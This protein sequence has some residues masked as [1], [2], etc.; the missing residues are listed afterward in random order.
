MSAPRISYL[1]CATARSGSSLLCEALG[2]TGLA[3]QPWEY[4]FDA[5]EPMWRGRWGLPAEAGFDDY[6]GRVLGEGATPNGVW[7]AKVMMGYFRELAG[8]LRAS[9]RCSR[10]RA[11]GDATSGEVLAEVFPALRYVWITRRDK[12]RQAVSLVRAIQTQSWVAQMAPVRSPEYDFAATDHHLQVV[13][14]HEAGWQEF[15]AAHGIVPFV[16]V[17]EDFEVRYQETALALLDFLGVARPRDLRLPPP[18]IMVR[19]ADALSQ[20][21][22]ARFL[23]EKRERQGVERGFP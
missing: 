9:S 1:I 20:E 2:S 18:R 15:F 21:W 5:H 6:L 4:F 22:V 3:G 14:L 23:A 17:Y 19:Q 7:G 13:T 11:G 10:R 12:V 8:R 16:V